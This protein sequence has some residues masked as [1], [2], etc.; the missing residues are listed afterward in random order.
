MKFKILLAVVFLNLCNRSG[1]V[2]AC[3][4]G[5]DYFKGSKYCFEESLNTWQDAK[6]DCE[7]MK[8]GNL[9]KITTDA[10]LTYLASKVEQLG[11][12]Y[13]IGLYDINGT[14]TFLWSDYDTAWKSFW[15]SGEP[16]I[17]ASNGCVMTMGGAVGRWTTTDCLNTNKYICEV[18]GVCNEG[19]EVHGG[20]CYTL[21]RGPRMD[22]T[23][24][25]QYCQ[26]KGHDGLV[27][28]ETEDKHSFVTYTL[29]E[30]LPPEIS[31][32]W[33][34]TACEKLD[35]NNGD[36]GT[37]PCDTLLPFVC[38]RGIQCT[39][40]DG[41]PAGGFCHRVVEVE[42][43]YDS[44][45]SYCQDAMASHLAKVSSEVIQQE[46]MTHLSKYHPGQK[47]MIGLTDNTLEGTFIWEDNSNI[48]YSNWIDFQPDDFGNNE[49]C[50]IIDVSENGKWEDVECD[51]DS[52]YFI[53]QV[54]G[55]PADGG[56]SSGDTPYYIYLPMDNYDSG[57][58]TVY[59]DLL[60][61][62]GVGIGVTLSSEGDRDNVLQ[63]SSSSYL[64]CPSHV[65]KIQS[66]CVG[67]DLY[68]PMMFSLSLWVYIGID[69]TPPS[70]QLEL[71]SFRPDAGNRGFY[72]AFSTDQSALTFYVRQE[73]STTTS[74]T[75][76]I[77]PMATTLKATGF[78]TINKWVHVYVSSADGQVKMYINGEL[79]TNDVSP[80]NFDTP[81]A[82][83][84]TGLTIGHCQDPV[85]NSYN[86]FMD[87]FW[88]FSDE[89]TLETTSALMAPKVSYHWPFDDLQGTSLITKSNIQSTVN[90]IVSLSSDAVSGSAIDLNGVDQSVNLGLF[91]GECLGNI[92]LCHFGFSVSFWYKGQ[93]PLEDVYFISN[94]G[95]A[96]GFSFAF[97]YGR[98]EVAVFNDIQKW[99]I[100]FMLVDNVWSHL[101][102][103]W[104]SQYGLKLY[105]DG[106]LVANE[107][108]G[109]ERTDTYPATAGVPSEPL[110]AAQLPNDVAQTFGKCQLDELRFWEGI[111]EDELDSVA[112]KEVNLEGC[113]DISLTDVPSDSTLDPLE[114]TPG[115]CRLACARSGLDFAG[116]N[117]ANECRCGSTLP[118]SSL[119]IGKCDYSCPGDITTYCGGL[120]AQSVWRST[121]FLEIADV[122]E[123]LDM[124]ILAGSDGSA[125]V[126]ESVPITLTYSSNVDV[127][128]YIDFGHDYFAAENPGTTGKVV[129]HSFPENGSYT[130]TLLANI[131]GAYVEYEYNVSVEALIENITDLF[132]YSE[133]TSLGYQTIIY[134]VIPTGSH[135]HCN[136]TFGD[137]T[138]VNTFTLYPSYFDEISHLYQ[139]EGTYG[140]QVSC[141][142]ALYQLETSITAVVQVAV[143]EINLAPFTSEFGKNISFTWTIPAG[144]NV[145]FSL[146]FD[147]KDMSRFGYS[148]EEQRGWAYIHVED[149]IYRGEHGL[150]L[151]GTNL[152]SYAQHFLLIMITDK[153][154]TRRPQVSHLKPFVA[155][156]EQFTLT[157][158][159]DG[160][161]PL[162]FVLDYGDDSPIIWMITHD[163]TIEMNKTF[164]TNGIYPVRIGIGNFAEWHEL[165]YPLLVN[166]EDCNFP[167]VQMNGD[168]QD[169]HNPRIHRKSEEIVIKSTVEVDC[170]ASI[171]AEFIWNVIRLDDGIYPDEFI[172]TPV[173]IEQSHYSEIVFK[174]G[175]F[176]I[177]FYNVSV[178]VG[179]VNVADIITTQ[180]VY[181]RITSSPLI[182]GL[183]GGSARKVA[184]T[185]PLEINAVELSYDPDTP[186]GESSNFVFSWYCAVHPE[187]TNI[188]LC[189]EVDL[190]PPH[191]V[192]FGIAVE[193]RGEFSIP[194]E[195]LIVG[196]F[197]AV[198]V[199][200]KK[201]VRTKCFGQLNEIVAEQPPVLALT[202]I[203]NCGMKVNPSSVLTLNSSCD[204]CSKKEWNEVMTFLWTLELYESVNGKFVTLQD[205]ES[206][207]ST[208]VTAS[209][210]SI[211]P[212][213]LQ[214]AARYRFRVYA[215]LDGK[216]G[217]IEI[218]FVTNISPYDGWC[219]VS[220]NSGYVLETEFEIICYDWMD[221]GVNRLTKPDPDKGDEPSTNYGLLYEFRSRHPGFEY[222]DVF[223]YGADPY[224]PPS[225]LP[226]G[227][228]DLYIDIRV[229]DSLGD[230]TELSLV[231]Q[232][233]SRPDPS[234]CRTDDI[235]HKTTG[236]KCELN[237]L[238]GWGNTG[239]VSQLVMAISS[240]LNAD[241][242]DGP[243][244]TVDISSTTT[245]STDAVPV[246]GPTCY[247]TGTDIHEKKMS[248]REN[249]L[250]TI[251]DVSSTVQTIS[252]AQQIAAALRDVTDRPDEIIENSRHLAIDSMDKITQRLS[253][254]SSTSD[255]D[256]VAC[257]DLIYGL[258]NV[259]EAGA[260][261]YSEHYIARDVKLVQNTTSTEK[262]DDEEDDL[263]YLT[264]SATVQGVTNKALKVVHD[265][266]M[267]ALN[268]R[269]VEQDQLFMESRTI[270]LY[271]MR[272]IP[273][274][275]E[276]S[277]ITI[278]HGSFILPQIHSLP[279]TQEGFLNLEVIDMR[280][281]YFSWDDTSHSV[282]SSVI[283]LS[284]TDPYKQ[285]VPVHDTADPYEIVFDS[286]PYMDYQ[287]MEVEFIGDPNDKDHLYF[288]NVTVDT[289][290]SSVS[291][292]IHPSDPLVQYHAYVKYE[293]FPSVEASDLNTTIPHDLNLTD[294]ELDGLDESVINELQFTVFLPSD[295]IVLRGI[296]MLALQEIVLNATDITSTTASEI[297]VTTQAN[298]TEE[299]MSTY[300]TTTLRSSTSYATTSNSSNISYIDSNVTTT[301]PTV[302]SH[303]LENGNN[304]THN[305]TITLFAYGCRYWDV[306]SQTWSTDGC[307][308]SP[309]SNSKFSRCLCDH[310]TSFGADFF[311][312]PNTINFKELSFSDFKDNVAVLIMVLI[313]IALYIL[314]YL[315]A[316]RADKQDLIKW[317]VFPLVD[318][319]DDDDYLY[320]IS[321]VT[322]LR[323]GASTKSKI[324]FQVFGRNDDTDVR[325]LHDGQR[326]LFDRGNIDN[327]LMAVNK[328]LGDIL[329][330][331]IWHDNSGHGEY[332]SW[333][334]NQIEIIDIQTS[335]RFH[336]LCDQWFAVDEQDGKIERILPAA[337][338]YNL[339]QFSHLF[340]TSTRKNLSENHLWFSVLS[341]PFRS[342]FN[343]VQRMACCFSLIFLT[344]IAGAMFYQ[345]SEEDAEKLKSGKGLKLGPIRLSFKEI[346]VGFISILITSPVSLIIIHLFRN[347]E[348]IP[349]NQSLFYGWRQLKRM[350]KTRR[351]NNKQ[352]AY[353]EDDQDIVNVT[354]TKTSKN[355]LSWYWLYIAWTLVF[356]SITVPSVFIIMY[357]MQ[358]KGEKS[359]R[360]L[361]SMAV[362]LINS[363]LITE[364]LKVVMLTF[365]VS[366]IFKKPTEE[367]DKEEDI[368]ML[369]KI[370]IQTEDDDSDLEEEESLS[371]TVHT[372]DLEI[373]MKRVMYEIFGYFILLM[374]L[375]S[376][377]DNNADI[378]KRYIHQSLLNLLVDT[379]PSFRTIANTQRAFQWM[380]GVL[381]PGMYPQMSIYGTKLKIDEQQF[382][383]M[384]RNYRVGPPR[385]RQ[386]RIKPGD[387][388]VPDS[389]VGKV[390][391]C[392]IPY[393]IS[394][395]EDGNFGIKWSNASAYRE[396]ESGNISHSNP[397]LF[398][399]TFD[400]GGM[401]TVGY[402]STYGGG[403]YEAVLGTSLEEAQNMT[404]YL[405]ENRWIDQYT[406]AVLVEFTLYNAQVNLFTSAMMMLEYPSGSA[407]STTLSFQVFRLYDF[408]GGVFYVI[409]LM[410]AHTTY[411]LYLLYN[412][413]M[414]FQ[415][416]RYDGKQYFS[417]FWNIVDFC[418]TFI[419]IT[420]VVMYLI[421]YVITLAN[422]GTLADRNG[423]DFVNFQYIAFLNELYTLFIGIVIYVEILKFLRL[424]RFNQRI[425]ML[426]ATIKYASVTLIPFSILFGLVLLSFA[427]FGYMIFGHTI[428]H[429]RTL[430]MSLETLL[431]TFI[432]KFY[433]TNLNESLV[434]PVYF[435]LFSIICFFILLNMLISIIADA[436]AEV[437]E[438]ASKQSNEYEIV[439]FM[440]Q[441]FMDNIRQLLKKIKKKLKI[442][443]KE[444]KSKDP[445]EVLEQKMDEVLL[446]MNIIIEKTSGSSHR[447]EV[448]EDDRDE[449]SS[450][451]D[452]IEDKID[453][454]SSSYDV[455]EDKIDE[456]SP[457]YEMVEDEID[458]SSRNEVVEDKIDKPSS[459]YEVV[460]DKI[461]ESSS[462][463]EEV[464]DKI[465][466]PSPSHDVVENK[467][468]KPSD[469]NEVVKD[470]IDEPVKG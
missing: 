263:E 58:T 239:A 56:S 448:I 291:I 100:H 19:E 356:L 358:W 351:R 248:I 438:D 261:Q 216:T 290:N 57:K 92:L 280:E 42:E 461:D 321:A 403:G 425:R 400:L 352:G 457:S 12:D 171:Y 32:V 387:C 342:S 135:V 149:Y 138:H 97:Q 283:G 180:N 2:G 203:N 398:R 404:K 416:L 264:E 176:D 389:M 81:M 405:F 89:V 446:K 458:E 386:L 463:N 122:P 417:Y 24:A 409:F 323:S 158:R 336:F 347:S 113:F 130:V 209:G 286:V 272:D 335:E 375:L 201:D 308:V 77:S 146:R 334:L 353:F 469:R 274:R 235:L 305:F 98:Y 435:V 292:I 429:Y 436:F 164:E 7:D 105:I 464:E 126:N 411:G 124:N 205:I 40:E 50:V 244:G 362:S 288:L 17:G 72:L 95:V 41:F 28:V 302:S 194:Q 315:W 431:Q 296:Y 51:L 276:N 333:F 406:R 233:Q 166:K 380:D 117:N 267:V 35:V 11:G 162:Y 465:D 249:M 109:F 345:D 455:I 384:S 232:V 456:P 227:N 300:P 311:V 27:G 350:L 426:A 147:G 161:S 284:F 167:K 79:N 195:D 252:S 204:S 255:Q 212:G 392:N 262:D 103:D 191:D 253:K 173:D 91:S 114:L 367:D 372:R 346:Y 112:T 289:A 423:T 268:G 119:P 230:F 251:N 421:R 83:I 237:T 422:A 277:T 395:E 355:R 26:V 467:I 68:C 108:E 202:C 241:S 453:G 123:L 270:D 271:L 432:G 379:S 226:L 88:Y 5:W 430:I 228:P 273:A 200:V 178:A 208:G 39:I 322:G 348:P 48:D 170:K 275:L 132:I 184:V 3:T 16:I 30:N 139:S 196:A 452:V 115:K 397:W 86:I 369:E 459:S 410:L 259:I 1:Q 189:D 217:Y 153:V 242:S 247:N 299:V 152:V 285:A 293:G 266:A 62:D 73:G 136:W 304:I 460:E 294:D 134:R 224:C 121:G 206:W 131:G 427:S 145:S 312:P 414:I 327:F 96:M 408:M 64:T 250:R 76:A 365:I 75:K 21:Y 148:E 364:P 155:E 298:M 137:G 245:P 222:S 360:W 128:L 281:N 328:P 420:L 310:L 401:P 14:G 470:K 442:G 60:D 69:I 192:C 172:E 373:Q 257:K 34:N 330:I 66:G 424:L 106:V 22:H 391:E 340:Y 23:S 47:L 63:F 361:T 151:N 381:L 399:S 238:S 221:E 331:R 101:F 313:I 159:V 306:E 256:I 287:E 61:C 104:V 449:P 354:K 282:Q 366:L 45:A 454:P 90:N 329:F 339:I 193:N 317:A 74:K 433:L 55:Y 466:E 370:K 309:R 419:G 179:M 154:S 207:T 468:D 225:K 314:M 70:G 337:G 99:R 43:N 59:P 258:G 316:R 320:Q 160:G 402:I 127:S 279:E 326:E 219:R 450:S 303:A 394:N 94:G 445:Y 174:P 65:S 325:I 144:S 197:Y 444:K 111:H 185:S 67:S 223:Y 213:Y 182:A 407:I 388:D 246:G 102:F 177:G 80:V 183:T 175:T 120:A 254:T 49:D 198:S 390:K 371:E 234:G 447:N 157:A 211:K 107:I 156:G 374:I 229:Y 278:K 413:F 6:T 9:A 52:Y 18:H 10:E 54:G 359:N 36:T 412:C 440:K 4:T 357:S 25:E 165:Y 428:P 396:N 215:T 443:S 376:I 441:R 338:R 260:L 116:I 231:V 168:G 46:L 318:N 368:I 31:H 343:R 297:D 85:C 15:D 13:W 418:Q 236:E 169:I 324:R 415:A 188:S 437:R 199:L 462:R 163:N 190:E 20:Y 143:T 87:E 218:E 243:L 78:L 141:S 181:V 383:H 301:I 118:T 220:P 349:G 363:L 110:F 53:C 38:K 344:M 44:A 295:Y 434:G 29:L 307:R 269:I 265:V 393:S 332:R 140:I 214:D 451:Y 125:V 142:N 187:D 341:R 240:E 8:G 33:T 82:S 210:I 186:A 93:I 71:L 129:Y 84:Q 382:L 133:P 319:K 439:D 377:V 385:L 37:E 378:N 150:E